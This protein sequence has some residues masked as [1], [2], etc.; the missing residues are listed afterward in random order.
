[1][2]DTNF[3]NPKRIR[4][5]IACI[6]LTTYK[7]SDDQGIIAKARE[8]LNRHNLELDVFPDNGQKFA[9]NTLDYGD[10]PI[11]DEKEAYQAL[12]KAVDA[13]LKQAGCHF[14]LPMPV[15]FGQ[16][17]SM[18]Y[19]IAPSGLKNISGGCMISPA[20]NQDKMTLL[21]EMGHCAGLNHDLTSGEPRNF[22]HEADTRTVLYRYQVEKMAKAM[23]AVG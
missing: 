1:M 5:T 12:R 20:V 11:P 18:G 9:F 7:K 3:R 15:I 4:L 8:V 13:K 19:G 16:Y 14:V 21:H 6:Y 10:E 23:F 17:Q 22:M 2:Y